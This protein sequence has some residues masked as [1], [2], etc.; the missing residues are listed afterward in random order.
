MDMKIN[1]LMKFV[2]GRGQPL[3]NKAK[4]YG[5]NLNCFKGYLSEFYQSAGFKVV[6]IEPNWIKGKEP[7]VYLKLKKG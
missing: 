5:N 4:K 6:K 2:K 1:N 7:I 3:I